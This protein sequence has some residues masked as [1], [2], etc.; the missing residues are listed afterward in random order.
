MNYFFIRDLANSLYLRWDERVLVFTDV[1]KAKDCI[2]LINAETEFDMADAVITEEPL[3]EALDKT[4]WLD[5]VL[6]FEEEENE[7]N[8]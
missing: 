3:E 1:E 5:P 4:F 2:L 8:I 6:K 7:N